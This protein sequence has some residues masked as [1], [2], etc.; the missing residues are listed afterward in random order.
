MNFRMLLL[1][2]L[3]RTLNTGHIGTL[4]YGPPASI[5]L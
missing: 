1:P 4:K 5:V 2:R 3:Y